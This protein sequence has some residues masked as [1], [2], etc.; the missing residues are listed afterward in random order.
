MAFAMKN[1]V[2]AGRQSYL[3]GRIKKN[4]MEN[5]L[6]QKRNYLVFFLKIF[7]FEFFFLKL[8]FSLIL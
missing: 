1:A 5:P 7:F 3:S 2:I 6:H 4:L 8:I